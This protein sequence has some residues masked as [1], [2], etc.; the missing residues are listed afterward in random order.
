[1]FAVGDG[2]VIYARGQDDDLL[3]FRHDGQ[4]K[5]TFEWS[6][7]SPSKVGHGWGFKHVFGG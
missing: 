1:V 7:N 4:L 5:G 3:W 2:G 6:S